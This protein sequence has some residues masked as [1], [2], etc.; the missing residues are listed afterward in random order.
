M[1]K[2]FLETVAALKEGRPIPMTTP[3][4][5]RPITYKEARDKAFDIIATQ[6]DIARNYGFK[7]I[8]TLPEWIVRHLERTKDAF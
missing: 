4:E 8:H 1:N 7:P 3:H 2:P 6:Y 5:E